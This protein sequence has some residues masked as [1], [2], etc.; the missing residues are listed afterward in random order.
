MKELG[1]RSFDRRRATKLKLR[2]PGL[3]RPCSTLSSVA[4]DRALS[5]SVGGRGDEGRR[6]KWRGPRKVVGTLS[7]ERLATCPIPFQRRRRE[8]SGRRRKCSWMYRRARPTRRLR[9]VGST[10]ERRQLS[11]SSNIPGADD[12]CENSGSQAS[13]ISLSISVMTRS[14]ETWWKNAVTWRLFR[15]SAAVGPSRGNKNARL[16]ERQ[17][18][19]SKRVFENTESK[20][21]PLPQGKHINVTLLPKYD[22]ARKLRPCKITTKRCVKELGGTW[23]CPCWR[24]MRRFQCSLQWPLQNLR[25]ASKTG[26]CLISWWQL[27]QRNF[28]AAPVEGVCRSL[29]SAMS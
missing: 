25:R 19:A 11:G 4:G 13:S 29:R 10:Q 24:S 6:R 20:A 15:V 14:L 22:F 16:T 26:V 23:F 18:R 3:R 28:T 5:F 1:R 21:H 17:S 27:S 7:A 8:G 2:F 12:F 9:A